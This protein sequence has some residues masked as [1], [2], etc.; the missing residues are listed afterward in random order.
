MTPK[1]LNLKI[2][3]AAS[4]IS[5]LEIIPTRINSYGRATAVKGQVSFRGRN[6]NV[7]YHSSVERDF[8]L[9]CRLDKNVTDVES[10]PFSLSFLT[11]GKTD[12]RIYTPDYYLKRDMRIGP[13]QFQI[14]PKCAE[15]IIEVKRRS[16]LQYIS[17]SDV[18]RLAA[19]AYWA[20]QD[21][22]RDFLIVTDDFFIGEKG[23]A[24]RLL[25]GYAGEPLSNAARTLI[26]LC[27]RSSPLRLGVAYD[28]LTMSG[29]TL[30]DAEEAVLVSIANGLIETAE[31]KIPSSKDD[32]YWRDPDEASD[33]ETGQDYG[34]S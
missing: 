1:E 18:E 19:G 7:D 28:L 14:S 12:S 13:S 5:A 21:P 16:D 30:E 4:L 15:I 34:T 26:D 17:N 23:E 8:V 10:Q 32:L 2:K 22:L 31:F 11:K 3:Q 20:M 25:S 6:L 24:I 33:T 9:A 27:K 29:Y